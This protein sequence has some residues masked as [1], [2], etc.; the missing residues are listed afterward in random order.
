MQCHGWPGCKRGDRA[1]IYKLF[2]NL[3]E[4]EIIHDQAQLI[5]YVSIAWTRRPET[6]NSYH[7]LQAHNGC[8]YR[9]SDSAIPGTCSQRCHHFVVVGSNTR[10]EF[11]PSCGSLFHGEALV[12]S[13]PM[14]KEGDESCGDLWHSPRHLASRADGVLLQPL[15]FCSP[16]AH[17]QAG[18]SH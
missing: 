10:L 13:L 17:R 16:L 3:C 18:C 5:L 2:A 4:K 6:T 7:S 12:E 9:H 11:C 15:A 14:G 1:R 8:A